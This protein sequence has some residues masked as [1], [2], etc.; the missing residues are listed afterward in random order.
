MPYPVHELTAAMA[1]GEARA[2]E[3][4]YRQYFDTMYRHACNLTRRDESFC[5]D[6][7]Q[8]AVLRV[9][10][11]V[12]P[13]DSEAQFARWLRLVT[14]TAA[15]DL[16]RAESRRRKREALVAVAADASGHNADTS[17]DEEQIARLRKQIAS[18]DPRIA[19]MI[20]LRCEGGWT[21][22]RIAQAMGLS[23]GTVDGRLRRAL[24]DLR[25]WATRSDNE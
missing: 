11:T 19:R 25:T 18:L 9:I 2:V 17:S 13:V 20:E 24:R 6:V 16:L 23:I 8:D 12:R 10:R 3:A 5:L 21:L 1:A 4:F 22:A 15:Y 14:Q 7:V